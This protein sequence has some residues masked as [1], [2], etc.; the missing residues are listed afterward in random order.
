MGLQAAAT[1][2]AATGGGGGGGVGGLAVA[3]GGGGLVVAAGAA[4]PGGGGGGLA[5][6][7]GTGGLGGGTGGL[8]GGL[9]GF[10]GFQPMN[11]ITYN[12]VPN[13]PLCEVVMGTLG[14]SFLGP[15][16]L[17][18]P[19]FSVTVVFDSVYLLNHLLMK[20]YPDEPAAEKPYLGFSYT[21][22]ISRDGSNWL[23]LFDYSS[24]LCYSTQSLV[25]PKQAIR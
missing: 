20:P 14:N 19:V 10:T 2:A 17:P 5:G 22:S 6:L 16:P 21:I 13:V 25:F 3:T 15:T 7:V 18:T 8:G 24:Y 4:A 11:R 23:P 12:G 1:G 9:T